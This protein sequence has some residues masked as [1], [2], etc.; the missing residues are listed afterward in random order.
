MTHSSEPFDA[1]THFDK[2]LAAEY[3]RRIRLF[4]PSYD[5][6]HQM[7]A[8]WLQR[9][10]ERADFLSAGCGAGAEIIH[11]GGRFP[12]WRFV[13][14]DISSSMLDAARRR[15]AEAG[16]ASRASFFH[17]RLQEYQSAALFDAAASVFVAHFIK[18]RDEKLSF[19][20]SIAAKLRPGGIFVLADLFGD[21][22]AP[23]FQ[24]LLDAWLLSYASHGISAEQLARDR[25]HIERD[26]DFL[27]EVELLA[28]LD[29]AGFVPPV[30]FYQTFLFGGWVAT[31]RL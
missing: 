26:L 31:K 24:R 27:P 9:L 20:R 6:L 4:C 21:E 10:P 25:A 1:T 14:V 3:D 18:G 22:G 29:E 7:T 15:V 23:E 17:G 5:A 30:R 2:H 12:S 19:F 28:L 8:A 11:L 13:G 16:I